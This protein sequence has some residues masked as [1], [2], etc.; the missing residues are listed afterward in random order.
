MLLITAYNL[1][2]AT[3]Y[4][5]VLGMYVDIQ[6]TRLAVAELRGSCIEVAELRG[7]CIE[8]AE[9]RGKKYRRFN[10]EPVLSSEAV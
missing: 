1:A 10:P 9:L 6:Y 7:N 4:L 2:A 3:L 5:E 8:V